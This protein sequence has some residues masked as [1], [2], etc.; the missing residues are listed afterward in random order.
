MIE[1][2]EKPATTET[3]T[4]RGHWR[5]VFELYCEEPGEWEPDP[6]C[7]AEMRRRGWREISACEWVS[8]RPR[9]SERECDAHGPG[10]AE[11]ANADH[12]RDGLEGRWRYLR[13]EFFPDL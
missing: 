2:I 7:A 10:Q 12:R 3:P 9:S 6:D 11:R 13:A 8:P 4:E 1:T 5:C